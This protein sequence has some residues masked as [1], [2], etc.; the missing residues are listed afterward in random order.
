MI[1]VAGELHLVE[2]GS[3]ELL[4]IHR[5]EY[6]SP[7]LVSIRINERPARMSKAEEEALFGPGG[8]PPGPRVAGEGGVPP[9]MK[10]AHLLDPQTIR[11]HDL[12]LGQDVGHIAHDVRI[13][14]LELNAR[15][16]L[17]LFRDTRRQLHL[18]DLG[19][20]VRQTML[21]YCTYVQWV[22]DSDVVVA[23][24][25]QSL[26]VWYNIHAPDR[27]TTYDIR[28]EVEQIERVDGRTVV[29][30]DEGSSEAHYKLDET[31]I[32][33]SAAVEDHDFGRAVS[34]LSHREEEE[35]PE[36]RAMWRTLAGLALGD[37]DMHVAER[38]AAALGDVAKARYLR[39]VNKIAAQ[40]ASNLG[41]D[42]RDF[43]LVR[44]RMAMLRG[45]LQ[46]AEMIFLDRGQADEAIE[47]Y[48][49]LQRWEDAIRVAEGSRHP[50][51][52]KMRDDYYRYLLDSHQ[53]DK[54]A[55][56][57]ERERDH[58]AALGL[59]LQAQMPA[60]AA[61]LINTSPASFGPDAMSRVAAALATAGLHEKAGELHERMNDTSAALEAYLKGHAYP[62]A[63]ELARRFDPE[64]VL[65]LEEACGDWLVGQK[66]FDAA[67][68][69][70]IE[71]NRAG[72]AVD[73][74]IQS[75]QWKRAMQLVEDTHMSREEASRFY[76]TAA[77]HFAVVGDFRAAERYFVA[78][79]KPKEGVEMYAEAGRWSEAN[80][81][82]KEHMSA[83][84]V[85]MLHISQAERLATAGRYKEAERLYLLASEPDLAISMYKKARKFEAM[86]RL[87]RKHRPDMVEETLLHLAQ[88]QELEG[89]MRD[90]ERFYA[91]AGKWQAAV[92]MYRHAS[93]WEDAIRVAKLHGG[94]DAADKVAY[95]WAVTL[96]D[97]EGARLL[98]RLNLTEKAIEYAV[99]NGNFENAFQL[100]K[101]GAPQRAQHVHL[102]YALHLED[103]GRF[104]EAERE[105][106]AAGKPKEA[107][108]MY[109]HDKMWD[110]AMNVAEKHDPTSVSDVLAAQANHVRAR[111][112]LRA[113]EQ[114]FL[115]ANRPEAA[116]GMYEEQRAWDDAAR[117][118]KAHAPHKLQEVARARQSAATGGG[119]GSGGMTGAGAAG[120]PGTESHAELLRTARTWEEAGDFGQAVDTYLRVTKQVV[121]DPEVLAE[122]WTS[123]VH[124]ASDHVQHRR[125][126]VGEE[127]A[128]RLCTIRRFKEAGDLFRDVEEYARAVECYQEAGE[129]QLAQQLAEQ[130]AP[131]LRASVSAAYKRHL[132]ET[133]DADVLVEEGSVDQGVELYIERGDWDKAL[134]AAAQQ[135]RAAS[136]R[137]AM[138]YA[139]HLLRTPSPREEEAS[140]AAAALAD[141]GVAPDPDKCALMRKLASSMLAYPVRGVPL[142]PTRWVGGGGAQGRP[143]ATSWDGVADPV[144]VCTL[145]G[146]G[147]RR[148]SGRA[149]SQG[150]AQP[151]D[152]GARL[153]GAAAQG[154]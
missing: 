60:R 69:H 107:I 5:T 66:Q 71:A 33:F 11:V 148:R 44:A 64:R 39:K 123:A 52:G 56:L 35:T 53:E 70:Y 97:E 25:R 133:K 105:F 20:Q 58:T 26:C 15:A 75:H 102:K 38:C 3:N 106:V 17:L 18:F 40:A 140:R 84:E 127:V 113:A 112:D 28:G 74:A 36:T 61:S 137:V 14:W 89:R 122:A 130:F 19:R 138:R 65:Q 12:A 13:D 10:I 93:M 54:A 62:R 6:M 145:A 50:E 80:A 109:V 151:A 104:Q 131:E 2:F 99:E 95:S 24:S 146:D 124:L 139:E 143:Q 41:G 92:N 115:D 120:M 134:R 76:L 136:A 63:V 68:N 49:T 152:G 34:V 47:M 8:P 30:V 16:D 22:P 4:G 91:E 59:Y 85:G 144:G 21:T 108:E 142:L 81:L 125:V 147:A 135:H 87:V 48:Q 1:Y 31:L 153:C 119:G 121:Q 45:D 116:I 57:K 32:G 42:G 23:Q 29:I 129:W 72:K 110:A 79:G 55:E 154:F 100:A 51:A 117:V 118:A 86:I 43:W 98:Q 73:A 141:Y 126:E 7:H 78:A 128:G 90:A 103:Q 111:G 77:R 88:Q 27:R 132:V 96:G 150:P 94:A 37:G 83:S 46:S 67:I 82:A 101:T 114:L 9:N 149:P